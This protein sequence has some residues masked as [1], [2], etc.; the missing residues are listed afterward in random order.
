MRKKE[1]E[2]REAMRER[3]GQS[4]EADLREIRIAWLKRDTDQQMRALLQELGTSAEWK[5][6]MVARLRA[7]GASGEL[8]PLIAAEQ[9]AF[10]QSLTVNE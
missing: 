2:A 6:E 1:V 5:E 8:H 3:L 10:V 7:Q 9:I 4:L